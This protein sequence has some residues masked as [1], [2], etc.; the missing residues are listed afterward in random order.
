MAK[1]DLTSYAKEGYEAPANRECPYSATSLTGIA[2]HVGVWMNRTGR[3]MPRDVRMA[4]GYTVWVN[5]MLVDAG[6]S[7]RIV[8]VA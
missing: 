6:D 7:P 2:W 3:T 8:R 1:K 4:R 5:D